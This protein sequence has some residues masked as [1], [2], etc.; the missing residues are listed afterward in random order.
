[1][2]IISKK[3]IGSA[4]ILRDHSSTQRAKFLK[5][6]GESGKSSIYKFHNISQ[7]STFISLPHPPFSPYRC[8][9][10]QEQGPVQFERH[11][12]PVRCAGQRRA[13]W[14]RGRLRRV[15]LQ[16]NYDCVIGRHVP[17]TDCGVQRMYSASAAEIRATGGDA[18]R[19]E[20]DAPAAACD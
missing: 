1:M 3:S 14:Q 19:A 20:L 9:G 5:T 8:S 6:Q 18:P 16:S 17:D 11:P 15:H 4:S 2:S 10:W 7:F 12:E 13:K